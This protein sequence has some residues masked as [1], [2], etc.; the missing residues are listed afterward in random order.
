MLAQGI[1]TALA[2]YEASLNGKIWNNGSGAVGLSHWI[3]KTKA[4]FQ[5]TVCTDDCWVKYATCTM[6]DSALTWCNNQEKSMGIAKA[7]EIQALEQELWNL[8][9]QGFEIAACT[10]RFNELANLC[11]GM[12]PSEDKKIKRYIWG[13]ASPVQGL[14]TASRPST[15][16]STLAPPIEKKNILE[17][18]KG[19]FMGNQRGTPCINKLNQNLCPP[20][21]QLPTVLSHL[22]PTL[23]LYLI[24]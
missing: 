17:V 4:D 14:V 3:E 8:T 1:A 12:V 18:S 16:D 13:L 2:A 7:Y 22:S 5:I 24:V 19:S 21:P 23:G 9:M 10:S 6:L 11:P 15:F 20:M